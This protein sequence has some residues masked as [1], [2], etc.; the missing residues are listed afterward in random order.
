[1]PTNVT[2]VPVTFY[3]LDS[4]NNYRSIGTTTTNALGGYSFTWTPDIPGNYTVTLPLQAQAR[5]TDL[6]RP[7]DSTP[8]P[9]QQQLAP[10]A[11]PLTGLASNTTV[12]YG[13]RS[14]RHH[15]NRHRRSPRI[16]R[17][18]KTPINDKKP[19]QIPFSLFLVL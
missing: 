9:Q 11:T 1:M 4:N 3:V 13:H 5:I 7:Q 2:G 18:K 15:H 19:K 12:E 8:T 14:H 16:A 6:L 10:T 17:H